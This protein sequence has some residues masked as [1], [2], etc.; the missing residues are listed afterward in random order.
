M[1]TRGHRARAV[2]AAA[3]VLPCLAGARD[4]QEA[5]APPTTAVAPP[6]RKAC[7][8]TAL[9]KLLPAPVSVPVT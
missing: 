2:I 6:R 8:S 7:S 5:A 4:D 1:N 3:L 9:A